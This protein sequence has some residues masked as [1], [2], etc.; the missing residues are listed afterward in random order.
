[1]SAIGVPE[2]ISGALAALARRFWDFQCHEFPLL[3][4]R[5]GR[6][7]AD[8]VVLREAPEDFE[9]RH[10]AAGDF[11][12]ALERI[13]EQGLDAQDWATH[14]LLRRELDD[15]RDFHRVRAHQRPSLYPMGPEF[16]AL[17][18][19]NTATLTSLE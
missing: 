17:S 7:T 9:R 4:V 6:K 8:A 15:L 18:F 19:A 14:R 12:R 16:T 10:Q 1:M 5:A 2:K 11:T 3:A 13:P